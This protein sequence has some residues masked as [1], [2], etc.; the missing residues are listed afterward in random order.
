[1]SDARTKSPGAVQTTGHAWDGDIQEFNNPLPNWWLWSFYATVLFALVYWVFYPAWP[2]GGT[3]TKGVMN[4]ITF[5]DSDGKE[6]TTH[7]N[8]RALLLKDLQDGKAARL[9]QDYMTKV[10]AASYADILGD[11]EMMAFTRSVAKGLFGDNCAPC[12]GSGGQGVMG[13]FPNLADDAWLWGGS[14]EDIQNTISQGRLGFMPAFRE[15]FNDQQ[16][17]DVADYVLSLSGNQVDPAASARG[18]ILFQTDAGGCYYCHTEAGTGL[19]SQGAANLT[20]QVWTIADVS[21][22]ADLETKK[23]RVESVISKGV[24]RQMPYWSERLSPAQI[25][26]LTVYVHELGGGQ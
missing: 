22:A 9:S 3:F 18:K 16:L 12:H 24:H 17:N 23:K 13:L 19:K 1:M 15:T 21:G 25:K 5:V 8:T 14:I 2:V 26:L 6:K 10:A 11:A 20:D 7:W 4:D